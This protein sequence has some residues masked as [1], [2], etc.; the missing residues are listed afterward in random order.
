MRIAPA[1]LLAV[2]ALVTA[3]CA[4][5]ATTRS[6]VTAACDTARMDRVE[7][8]ARRTFKEVYWM[9]CPQASTM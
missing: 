6:E 1:G 4:P 5:V 8:D 3:A 2:I 7:R 9:R